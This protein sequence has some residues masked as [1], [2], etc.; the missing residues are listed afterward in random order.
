MIKGVIKSAFQIFRHITF[1]KNPDVIFYS[2]QH[3][4][5][6]SKGLNPYFEPLVELCK[7]NGISYLCFEE[8]AITPYPSDSSCIRADVFVWLL[9]LIHKI[10][11]NGFKWSLHKADRAAGKIIDFITFHRLRA[12][13]YIT[14]SNSLIDVLGEINPIGNVYDYQHG[15]I[16]HGHPG[17]FINNE[18][19]RPEF[20]IKNRRVLLWGNLYK[21]NL[22]NL[23]G[24]DNPEDKFIVVGYPMYNEVKIQRKD[25]PKTILV[26]MQFTSDI[27][28]ETSNGMLSMLDEFAS[29]AVELGN[30]ILLKHHPR[31]AGEID[32]TPL[33]NK[34]NG[35]IAI[36]TQSLKELVPKIK[37]HV[38]W[39]STTA[40]EYASYGIPTIFLR[41]KRFDWATE[42]FY[43]QYNYPLYDNIS[44]D[45]VLKQIENEETY[46][47]DCNVVKQWYDSAY[48]TLDKSLLLKILN[49]EF[50]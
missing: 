19:L 42:M 25:V 30:T 11:I 36:T 29:V 44:Y 2:P 45:V 20:K 4:N 26:S 37:I 5:R 48:S 24:I 13:T 46:S 49:G 10:C 31:F 43:G 33:I 35:H 23:P 6:S 47:S 27:A 1:G 17:Y 50:A 9:W 39:G 32:L 40:M 34:Y 21:K 12:K 7:K 16:Y 3:F 8:P 22:I 15:I 28:P 14:I 38:T 41:D 18:D